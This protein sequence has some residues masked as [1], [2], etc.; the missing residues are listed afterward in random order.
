[1]Q[2]AFIQRRE[3]IVGDCVQLATDV[4]VYNEMNTNVEPIQMVLDFTDDVTERWAA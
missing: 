2:R 3:Q 4:L 1:M